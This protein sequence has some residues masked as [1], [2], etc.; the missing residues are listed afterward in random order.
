MRRLGFEPQKEICYNRLLPYE[1][2]LDE[3]SNRFLAEIKFNLGRAVVLRE[4]SPGA[5]YWSNRLASYIKLYGRKFSKEDHIRFV[6][7]FF[8]LT[9][10]PDLDAQYVV[11]FGHVLVQ[12]L[13]KRELISRDDLILPW[14]P[15]YLAVEFALYSKYESVGLKKHSLKLE[16]VLKGVVRVSRVYFSVESTQEMLDEWRPLLCPYDVTFSKAMFYLSLFLPTTLPIVHHDKGFKLWLEE[17]LGIWQVCTNSCKWEEDCLKLFSRLASDTIGCIDWSPYIPTIFTRLM[18]TF[19]LPIGNNRA[20][21]FASSCDYGSV[22]RSFVVWI[23]STLGGESTTQEHITKMFQALESFY[24]P[25]NLGRYTGKLQKLLFK[26]PSEVIKR[27]HKEKFQKASWVLPTPEDFKLKDTDIT[28]FVESLKPTVMLAI[29]NKYGS[30]DAA[31]ALQHLAMMKPEIVLPTLLDKLYVALDTLIEP[32]QLTATLNCVTSVARALVK[33]NGSFPA[34]KSHVLPLLQLV[35]PG[36]DPNDFRKAMATFTFISTIICLVPVVDCSE[37]VGAV[38]MTEEEKELCLATSQFEDFVVQF[39]DRCFVMIEN[40]SLEL[41]SEIDSSSFKTDNRQSQEGMMGMGVASTFHTI[42]MQSSPKIFQ[43]ALNKLFNFCANNVLETKVAGKIAADMCR[44]AAKTSAKITLK[45]FLP[46]CFSVI[47]STTSADGARNDE[48]I[49]DQLLW[50]L[51]ILSEVVRSKGTDILEYRHEL[52]RALKS[53]IHLKN[54]E[55]ATMAAKLLENLLRPLSH[56]YPLEWKSVLEDFSKPVTEHLFIRD[57]GKSGDLDNLDIKW[58]IPIEEEKLF[59]KELLDT[60]LQPEMERVERFMAGD[61]TLSREQLQQSLRIIQS[62]LSGAAM[63]LPDWDKPP[64]PNLGLQ[65]MVDRGRFHNTID[66][67]PNVSMGEKNSR[68]NIAELIH[69][70][71]DHLMQ[72]HE[73]DTKALQI[74]VKIYESLM[75]H[76][77]GQRDEF[78]LRWRSAGAV[79]RAMEDKLTGKKKHVRALLIERVQLQHEMRILDRVSS[80]LTALHKTLLEDLFKLSTSEYTEV[81]IKAQKV[82]GMCIDVF[83]YFARTMVPSILDKLRDDPEV[84]HEAFKGSLHILLNNRMFFLVIHYWEVMVDI[85]PAIIQA[86]HSEKPTITTLISLLGERMIKKF[87]TVALCRSISDSAASCGMDILQSDT[88]RPQPVRKRALEAPVSPLP[89]KEELQQADKMAKEYSERNLSNYTKLVEKLT[90]LLE[91]ENLRWRYHQLCFSFL[92]SLIRWDHPMPVRAV[93]VITRSLIHDSLSIRKVAISAVGALLKQQKRPHLKVP[94]NPYAVANVPEPTTTLVQPGDRPDNLWLQYSSEQI[95]STQELWDQ[96]TFI[97]KTHWGYYT[98]PKVLKTYAPHDK[99]PPLSRSREQLSEGEQAIYDCFIQRDFVDKLVDFLSLEER[100][101]KDKFSVNRFLLFKGLFRN[102]DDTFLETF[103]PHLE[104]LCVDSQESTQR[105]GVEII[106]ALI[107]GSKHWTFEKTQRMWKFL[108]PLLRKAIPSITVETLE[109]WGT[110][111]ATAVESRDP[112]RIHWL[113]QMMLDDPIGN[114]G[115]SFADSTRL[116]LIQ[117]ALCQQ[118]WRV[119]ELLHKL[120]M[121]IEP[122][123][124]HTYKNVRDRSGSVLCSIL[125]YDISLPRSLPTRSPRRHD[126][127]DMMKP[128]LR[129]LQDM[130]TTSVGTAGVDMAKVTDGSPESEGV[131]LLKTITNWLLSHAIRSLN[132]CPREFFDILPIITLFDSQEENPELQHYCQRTISYMSQLELPQDL[133]PLAFETVR[134]IAAQSL[135]YAKKSIVSYLQVMVFA[136][137]F[138]ITRSPDYIRQV[139]DLV[140]DM[141]EDECLEVRVVA[142]DT[143]SGLLHYGIFTLEKSVKEKFRKLANTKLPRKRKVGDTSETVASDKALLKRHTGVLGLACCVKAFPYDVPP[144]LPEMLMELGNHLHDPNPIQATVKSAL[145]DFRRTHHD[146]WQEHKQMF[147]DDQL[148]VLTDLLISPCYYA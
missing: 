13:K 144:W 94:V 39:M 128:K 130:A 11:G 3:E 104:R 62:C 119:A 76:L 20:G 40:S 99:Q 79:K 89:S 45:K 41:I 10:I 101:G 52:V 29:F 140:L 6:K 53:T 37:A 98:W 127:V 125:M 23:V 102:F 123:L 63:L 43:V 44:A 97:D 50:N 54:K 109:D 132:S 87:N 56:I 88:P 112:H 146:N 90:D 28:A 137:L 92:R 47:E 49:D 42:L 72:H 124:G 25:S 141:L 138:T 81:R 111:M 147:T 116:Y 60:F 91:S 18:R 70:L 61:E 9:T 106:A 33:P 8:G 27:L 133:L 80:Q 135:W 69:K 83:D 59:A 129:C 16:E 77:G 108:V 38:D 86:D 142:A 126:F 22:L 14:R 17:F 51:Q 85:W 36:I 71:L 121:R 66:I 30:Y 5:L 120:L 82:M 114:D 46:R 64:L 2:E 55:G 110:F 65:T 35:L 78:D 96:C 75:L 148:L 15:L 105:C 57:W 31:N 117:G 145:S 122:R 67:G 107:R 7:L 84:S 68:E 12:L 113:L 21:C 19:N 73:D 100:K 26:L 93:R 95:P 115:T 34:G 1:Q 131:C 48:E 143:F 136:N 103:K 118:E 24:H 4:A 58:H 139:H 74:I 134:K 32:H